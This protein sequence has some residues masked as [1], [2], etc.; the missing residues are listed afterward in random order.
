M[1]QRRWPNS[2]EEGIG[3]IPYGGYGL[4]AVELIK[5][6]EQ[7]KLS[8]MAAAAKVLADDPDPQSTQALARAVTDK[9]WVVR[10]AVLEAIAKRADPSLLANIQTAISDENDHVRYTAAAAVIRLSDVRSTKP[11]VR[12]RRIPEVQATA[13]FEHASTSGRVKMH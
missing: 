7:D 8:A 4:T 11:E 3:F 6:E 5:K 12:D 13:D 2:L 1:T 9:S 10:V